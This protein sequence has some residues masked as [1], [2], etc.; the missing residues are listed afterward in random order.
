MAEQADARRMHLLETLAESEEPQ[1]LETLASALHCDA[2]TIRRDIDQLQQVFQRVQ[3]VEVRR[4]H[5]LVSRAGYSPGYFTDH[6]DRNAAA[7]EAIARAIVST[8]PDDLAIVLT[9]G[10]TPYA[11][12]REM[13]RA[14]VD[15]EPPHNLIVFTNSVPA[16][17]ELV[18]AGISTG[19]LGEIYAPEDCAFHAPEFRSAFQPGLAIVGASGVLFSKTGAAGTLDLF[20][21]RAEEAAFM[22]QLLAN[23]PEI[24]VAV[25]SS[26]LGRR[27][28]WSFGGSALTGKSVR[29]VTDLLTEAQREELTQLAAHLA[30]TGTQFTFEAVQ[31]E[32][33]LA[34]D[35]AAE[36]L[37]DPATNGELHIADSISG[38]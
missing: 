34:E 21:H 2:R 28:P 3:N 18:A 16:L 7:K 29:L 8:L 6:L 9:A 38:E 12:A 36:V 33:P 11:I 10:S 5:V 37:A 27:H 35:I 23:V 20:S 32:T 14:V 17:M 24:I 22:K 30:R 26:K 15:G 25:D 13:R 31:S 1:D 19:V 4:S